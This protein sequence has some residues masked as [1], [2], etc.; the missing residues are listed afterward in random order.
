MLQKRNYNK[1]TAKTLVLPIG[2]NIPDKSVTDTG[3]ILQ[4]HLFV[5]D[6]VKIECYILIGKQHI[7]R[8][9]KK[10]HTHD[11]SIQNPFVSRDHGYFETT[12]K[13]VCYTASET[14]NGIYKNRRRIHPGKT[15]TLQDGDELIIPSGNDKDRS[16]YITLICAFSEF[17]I[18]LWSSIMD[19]Q[20]D[21]L[22][23]LPNRKC[24]TKCFQTDILSHPQKKQ[25]IFLLDIDNFKDINDTYGH[26]AGDQA[27]RILADELRDFT[28][29][30]HHL[31]R[32]GG[33]EFV[34][35]L[36]GD[37][38]EIVQTLML[39]CHDISRTQIISRFF[40][41]I[42]IGL[43]YIQ[44]TAQTLEMLVQNADSALYHTKQKG[45]NGVTVYEQK[46]KPSPKE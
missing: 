29:D 28:S 2:T 34:G 13:Q 4:P 6:S 17:R 14:T 46:D 26:D 1:P 36:Q 37:K 27:L 30:I 40:I 21:E 12:K 20:F 38:K 35:V 25:W 45:G 19:A 33:D 24:F 44:D 10:S 23:R 43:C 18:N 8:M 42:S 7:G 22:T 41:T 9:P 15:I 32:W 5:R 31:G 39:M 3:F 11:I 16:N